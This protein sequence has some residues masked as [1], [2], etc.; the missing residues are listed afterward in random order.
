MSILLPIVPKI[1]KEILLVLK[2]KKLYIVFKKEQK[3]KNIRTRTPSL[4]V[5]P[6]VDYVTRRF[7]LSI[8]LGNRYLYFHYF[9]LYKY[10]YD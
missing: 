9:Y 2:N 3:R 7:S 6:H 8:G 5:P 4:K 1:T 10:I